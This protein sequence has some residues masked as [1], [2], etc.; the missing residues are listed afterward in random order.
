MTQ[1]I[2]TTIKI[3]RQNWLTVARMV[4]FGA[5]LADEQGTEVLLPSRYIETPLRP[6]DEIEVFVYTDS[7]DRP[8][9]TTEHPFAQVGEVAFLQVVE[10]N[11]IG[12]FLDW[13]LMKNLLVPFRE[14]KFTMKQGGIYPVYIYLDHASGR[15]AASAKIE[16]YLGNTLPTY[17]RGDAVTALVLQHEE[18]GYKVVVDNLF[19]G[20]LYHNELFSQIV[21]GQETRAYVKQVRPDG[22]IDLTLS[23]R[24]E[25]RQG[26]L[27]DVILQHLRDNGGST[28]I[29]DSSSPDEIKATF[30][31]SKKDYKK[32]LGALYKARLVTI[33]PAIVSLT[34]N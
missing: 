4:E 2:S 30:H 31:C 24:A 17:K 29:T 14:Q 23:D 16:K 12:A 22:K 7:E 10:V 18:L 34:S 3:G 27:A 21:V 8:I 9:A 26:D 19:M 32:A 13:G 20:M 33:T 1:K 28:T 5:Y 15:I 11:R 25:R 6:G